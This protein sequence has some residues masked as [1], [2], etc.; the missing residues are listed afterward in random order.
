MN[1]ERLYDLHTMILDM[2]FKSREVHNAVGEYIAK[3]GYEFSHREG[4]VSRMLA[5]EHLTQ[6]RYP[7]VRV[8]RGD[9]P[10]HSKPGVKAI[11]ASSPTRSGGID[12]VDTRFMPPEFMLIAKPFIEQ[13]ERHSSVADLI[14]EKATQV[15]EGMTVAQERMFVRMVEQKKPVTLRKTQP[16]RSFIDMIDSLTD[17]HGATLVS[18]QGF[19]ALVE[20]KDF[21]A[22]W[23]PWVKEE[24]KVKQGNMGIW[25][26]RFLVY[27]DS[28]RDPSH[29]VVSNGT[30]YATGRPE[31]AG[32]WTDRG[33]WEADTTDGASEGLPGRGWMFHSAASL[34]V[35]EKNVAWAKQRT[36]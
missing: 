6:G 14:A 23:R 11:Y 4:F 16:G 13:R 36:R 1:I 33:G 27:C 22:K 10:L 5:G 25:N 32:H 9:T 2:V 24:W 15:T 8:P 21:I 18:E 20:D 30:M 12:L 34:V 31:N 7:V 3:K 26:D 17:D 28:T 29:R 19:K 35:F